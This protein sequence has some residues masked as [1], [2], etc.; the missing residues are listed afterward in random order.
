M[1]VN[2]TQNAPI[3][4]GISIRWISLFVLVIQNSALALAMCYSRT[5][6]GPVYL[7]ST[8]VM[9]AEA[10]KL[11][12]SFTIYLYQRIFSTANKTQTLPSSGSS[13]TPRPTL[14]EMFDEVYGCNS[15]MVKM[16]VPA[17]LY[18]VQNNLQFVAASNLD[19]ATFQVTYQSKILTTAILAVALLRQRIGPQKW[20]ALIVLTAGVSIAQLPSSSDPGSPGNR[21]VG[22]AAVASA[23]V[24][25]GL[26][27]VYFEKILKSHDASLWLRNIQLGTASFVIASLGALCWDHKAIK[28]HGFFYGYSTVTG[29]T[30]LIQA[31]GG[32]VVALVINYTDNIL[33]GFA[34]SIS[35]ILSTVASV[36]IFH[37][38][39]RHVFVFGAG[40]VLWATYLY[41]MAKPPQ[42]VDTLDS[43]GKGK[44]NDEKYSDAERRSS[45]EKFLIQV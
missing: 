12:I 35:I 26:A 13:Q 37:Y 38:K 40:L 15:G 2:Q 29:I 6:D 27:G 41:G 28:T 9:L 42:V 14:Y 3:V 36:S 16:L 44:V 18:T 17:I 21:L 4:C 5:L 31:A 19:A 33:K 24:L 25:S 22:F 32:L 7:S 45:A 34:T 1:A 8:A 30:I 20:F 11:A 10:V 43:E 23:C 39:I